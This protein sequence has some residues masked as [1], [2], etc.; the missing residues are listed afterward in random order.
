MKKEGGDY[1]KGLTGNDGSGNVELASCE[2]CFMKGA[3][4]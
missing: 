2:V 4:K 3:C 1:A